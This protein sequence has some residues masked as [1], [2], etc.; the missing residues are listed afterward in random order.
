[1]IYTFHGDVI[2]TCVV[3]RLLGTALSLE[4]TDS[5]QIK[6]RELSP[7]AHHC[8]QNVKPSPRPSRWLTSI[9]LPVSDQHDVLVYGITNGDGSGYNREDGV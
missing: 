1:M 4:S 5:S 6:V 9:S 3:N 8:V 7:M 2:A